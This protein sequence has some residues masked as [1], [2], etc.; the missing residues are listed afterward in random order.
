[1]RSGAFPAHFTP[2]KAEDTNVYLGDTLTGAIESPRSE[3][4]KSACLV[5]W[6]RSDSNF[7]MQLEFQQL[8]GGVA[9]GSIKLNHDMLANLPILA[10]DFFS[11]SPNP[12]TGK[13]GAR[14][15]T[16]RL[17]GYLFYLQV[18]SRSHF[19]QFTLTLPAASVMRPHLPFQ[20]FRARAEKVGSD[21]PPKMGWDIRDVAKRPPSAVRPAGN[22]Y[23]S[24]E[25]WRKFAREAAEA[26]L[27]HHLEFDDLMD[28]SLQSDLADCSSVQ[29]GHS[30]LIHHTRS[31]VTFNQLNPTRFPPDRASS[32]SRPPW[33][34]EPKLF[35]TNRGP[36]GTAFK[37]S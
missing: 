19:A 31:G 3:K 14:F 2:L 37:E 33:R 34:P 36:R 32:S 21:Q 16:S 8:G 5:A 35:S 22:T 11:P 4:H 30:E 15:R 1:M 10:A 24:A 25:E 17:R 23:M 13:W 9:P 28:F 26:N 7:E 27:D 29:T 12:A 6:R 18:L 20:L